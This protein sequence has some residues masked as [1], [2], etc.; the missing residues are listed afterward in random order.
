MKKQDVL[1]LLGGAA[2]F[3]ILLFFLGWNPIVAAGLAVATYYGLS[4][5]LRPAGKGSMSSG[6]DEALSRQLDDARDDLRTIEKTAEDL[7][8]PSMKKDALSLWNTGTEIVRYLEAH[9]DQIPQARRFLNYYLDTAAAIL[10][11]YQNFVSHRPPEDVLQK[12]TRNAAEAVKTLRQVFEDQ[13]RRLLQGEMMD[14]ATD[15]DVL[16]TMAGQDGTVL[17]EQD[18]A[19]EENGRQM[20][21][22]MGGIS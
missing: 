3:V 4:L 17:Q 6:D 16:K 20:T 5:L 8:A 18:E 22:G 11:K 13:Y 7:K 2:V 9:M 1:G 12:E 19:G 10:T 15:V 14:M 21:G